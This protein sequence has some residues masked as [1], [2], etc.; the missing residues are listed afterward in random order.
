MSDERGGLAVISH[1]LTEY[2]VRDDENR[3]MILTLVKGLRYPKVGLPPERVERREQIGSQCLGKHTCYYAL[4][5]HEG[6]WEQ[7][8]VFEYT[9]RFFTPLKLVQCGAT[10]GELSVSNQFL[11][12]EPEELILSA[13]K[14]CESRSTVIVRLFNP[15]MK[16]ISGKLQ[17]AKPIRAAWRANLNE[18]RQEELKLDTDGSLAL[19]VAHKK[20]VTVELEI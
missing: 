20:I 3:T 8:K 13:V 14:K 9:Y 11:K 12:L 15:T 16:E 18:E 1:G 19:K 7:G 17:F 6:N 4:Y 5:P 10:P 2:E